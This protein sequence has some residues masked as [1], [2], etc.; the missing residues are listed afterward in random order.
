MGHQKYFPEKNPT[1]IKQFLCECLLNLGCAWIGKK[2]QRS[3][4]SDMD[5]SNIGSSLN[6]Q[7]SRDILNIYN[8]VWLWVWLG[9]AVVFLTNL[10]QTYPTYG[11]QGARIREVTMY[12]EFISLGCGK[13][14]TTPL[15]CFPTN[16]TM[17]TGFL[18]AS[19]YQDSKIS[20]NWMPP[21]PHPLDMPKKRQF[22]HL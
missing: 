1:I 2:Q 18:I 4:L 20:V 17:Y 19:N 3:N 6:R 12:Y 21:I 13:C 7:S 8:W 9:H 5:P 10:S 14:N 16:T 15:H 22:I 11:S